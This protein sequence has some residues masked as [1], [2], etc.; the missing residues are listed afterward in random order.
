MTI[1]RLRPRC[2]TS[3]TFVVIPV[4]VATG[5]FNLHEV[6]RLERHTSGSFRGLG[7]DL[8]SS[9]HFVAISLFKNSSQFYHLFELF[10][11]RV[12]T[13]I[14]LGVVYVGYQSVQ[15]DPRFATEG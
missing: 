7:V 4:D 1:S 10:D 5:F 12:E 3:D 15:S 14:Q 9:H 13:S 2:G 11:E 8:L 6:F